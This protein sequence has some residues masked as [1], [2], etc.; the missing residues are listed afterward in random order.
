[1]KKIVTQNGERERKG[2]EINRMNAR[3]AHGGREKKVRG[4]V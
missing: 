1:L 2:R 3:G 4:R